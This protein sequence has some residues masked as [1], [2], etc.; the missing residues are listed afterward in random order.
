MEGKNDIIYIQI[1]IYITHMYVISLLPA[2]VG[3][4]GANF[5]TSN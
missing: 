5:S 4:M 1:C 2:P 3:G